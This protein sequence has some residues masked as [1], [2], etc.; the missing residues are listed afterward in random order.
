MVVHPFELSPRVHFHMVLAYIKENW[1][2]IL[3]ISD[4]T[5]SSIFN[6]N[7][8]FNSMNN[9]LWTITTESNDSAGHLELPQHLN[10][11]NHAMLKNIW[12]A[13]KIYHCQSCRQII[14][15]KSLI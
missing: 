12:Y 2:E 5:I 6:R 13:G 3:G 7:G 8:I 11:C 1:F 10:N 14:A 4:S 15:L 9:A